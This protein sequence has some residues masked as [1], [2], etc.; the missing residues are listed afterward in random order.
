[1]LTRSLCGGSD[2]YYGNFYWVIGFEE[3]FGSLLITKLKTATYQ[4]SVFF[5]SQKMYVCEDALFTSMYV[6]TCVHVFI[7]KKPWISRNSIH[8]V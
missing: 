6:P 5:S 2:G 1:M 8:H 4:A 7:R 3:I